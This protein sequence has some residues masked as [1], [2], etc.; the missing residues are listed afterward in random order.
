MNF[1]SQDLHLNLN[2]FLLISFVTF[3]KL[4]PNISGK[5][6]LGILSQ[7]K[8]NF[9][10]HLLSPYFMPIDDKYCEK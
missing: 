2:N 3:D 7:P 4:S 9:S 6:V 5:M 10:E 8:M 1:K